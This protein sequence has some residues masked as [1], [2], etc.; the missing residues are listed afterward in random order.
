MTMLLNAPDDVQVIRIL[1][2]EGN[3]V[4]ISG[5]EEITCGSG[6]NRDELSLI[7]A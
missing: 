6:D 3:G 2:N 7:N 1:E 4:I 5:P